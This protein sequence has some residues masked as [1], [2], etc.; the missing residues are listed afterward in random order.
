M[1]ILLLSLCTGSIVG[2]V[3]NVSEV[4]TSSIFSVK[5]CGMNDYLCIY[6]FRFN[7]PKGGG[8]KVGRL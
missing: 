6:R 2:S 3:L 7:T 8:M 4:C 5:K 1:L